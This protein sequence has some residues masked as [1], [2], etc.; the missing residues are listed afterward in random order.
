MAL[1][2]IF[3]QLS[4]R[5]RSP[6]SP[7][8]PTSPRSPR[9]SIDQDGSANDYVNEPKSPLQGVRVRVPGSR[10]GHHQKKSSVDLEKSISG[11]SAQSP[12]SM[13]TFEVSTKYI[14]H[15]IDA[16]LLIV[17]PIHTHSRQASLAFPACVLCP[18]FQLWYDV[19]GCTFFPASPFPS[20][21][22]HARHL[23]LG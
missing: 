23:L 22:Q 7:G 13:G 4:P 19:E 17:L 16:M 5:P 6:G 21:A 11:K 15:E 10:D 20:T 2:S 3:S 14:M 8:S 18:A 12:T 1:R 9:A